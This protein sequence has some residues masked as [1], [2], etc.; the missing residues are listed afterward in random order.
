MTKQIISNKKRGLAKWTTRDLL[1]TTSLSLVFAILMLGADYLL[2]MFIMPLGPLAIY[3]STGIW[4][5]P[6]I[7]IIYILR[8]PGVVLLS[9]LIMAIISVPF[10]PFGWM[11]LLGAVVVG[12]P[13]ELVFWA[14]RYRNYHLPVLLMGGIVAG[15]VNLAFGWV[16]YGISLLAMGMQITIV[17]ASIVSGAVGGW[18]AKLLADAIAKTGVLSN[19]AVG[20]ELQEEV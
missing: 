5:I 8:R 17:V 3:A 2:A 6:P 7:F 15:V 1:V 13:I 19:Y 20:Q 16:P 9:Q 18:L 11:Q 4:F 14:T 10:S 12:L